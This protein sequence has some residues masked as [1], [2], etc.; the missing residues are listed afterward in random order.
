M[1]RLSMALVL[2]T[3]L[4]SIS[5]RAAVCD[6]HQDADLALRRVRDLILVPATLNDRPVQMVL[7]TGS[8]ASTITPDFARDF[9]LVE[10]T[11][12]GRELRGVGGNVRTGTVVATT[13]A[14]G[15]I[16]AR[17]ARFSLS[18]TSL[19]PDELPPVAGLLGADRLVGY[20]LDLD[21]PNLRASLYTIRSCPKFQ[22]WPGVAGVSLSRTK[23]GLS[24]VVVGVNDNAVRALVDTGA[25]S[26]IMTRGL[27]TSLGVTEGMLEADP[28]VTRRG[29][30]GARIDVRQHRFAEI[31]L[32]PV[33]WR[34]VAVGVADVAIPGVDML[35]GADLLGRQRIWLSPSRAMLWLR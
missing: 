31:T 5:A 20:D 27:A 10:D 16:R 29:V 25:R 8:E 18:V 2:V 23:S 33:I 30:N 22:P 4:A 6:I 14:I 24:I 3:L 9:G 17:Q 32:G 35:L 13:F 34:D 26:S 11:A 1:S 28:M 15:G 21:A 7:D 19:L 12:R